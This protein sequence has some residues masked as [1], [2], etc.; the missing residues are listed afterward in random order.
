MSTVTGIE[1]PWWCS[2]ADCMA[3]PG[4]GVHLSRTST[5][6]SPRTGLAVTVQLVQASPVPGYPRTGRPYV[7]LVVNYP[8]DGPDYPAQEYPFALERDLAR[9]VG[10]MLLNATRTQLAEERSG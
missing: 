10:W 5:A 6:R 8:D 2:P 4:T 7:S 1:H 9:T 3:G